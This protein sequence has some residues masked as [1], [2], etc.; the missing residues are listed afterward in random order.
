[1]SCD[2]ERGV[3]SPCEARGLFCEVLCPSRAFQLWLDGR[4]TPYLLLLTGGS[5]PGNET[6]PAAW[7]RQMALRRGQGRAIAIP[8]ST[9]HASLLA[10]EWRRALLCRNLFFEN[11]P[12]NPT[13]RPRCVLQDRHEQ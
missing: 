8:I 7:S 4:W 6:F 10:A 12:H 5:I 3:H 13:L 2:L 1:M 9:P 11:M